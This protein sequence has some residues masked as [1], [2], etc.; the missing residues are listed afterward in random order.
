MKAPHIISRSVILI[1]IAGLTVTSCK[2]S[3]STSESLVGKWT[4]GT[5][6]ITM[7][8]GTKTL[9]QYYTDVMGL[10]AAQALQ[11]TTAINL[12]AMQS[13]SGTITFKSDNT[14]TS[15]LGGVTDTGTWSLS[16]DGKTLTV[17]PTGEAPQVITISSLTANSLKATFAESLSEDLNGDGTNE[18]ITISADLP[19]TR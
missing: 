1:L 17:T 19:F 12:V 3:S 10:T 15:N 14:Y 11:Y 4:A 13:F 8:V 9:S 16:S 6:V 7:M 18:T 2:K 5:P